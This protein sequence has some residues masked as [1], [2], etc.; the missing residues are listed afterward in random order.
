ML[1]VM[2]EWHLT[3]FINPTFICAAEC[4]NV[5]D[6]ISYIPTNAFSDEQNPCAGSSDD[7]VRL[8]HT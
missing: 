8:C 3:T 6:E 5:S 7:Q 4:K 1:V 2:F